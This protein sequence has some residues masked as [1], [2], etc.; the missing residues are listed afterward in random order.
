VSLY[1]LF[2]PEFLDALEGRVIG[3]WTG[4][5]WRVTVGQTSPLRTNSRGARWNPPGVEVLYASLDQVAAMVE[6]EHL[7]S[8]QSVTVKAPRFVSKLEVNLASVMDLSREDLIEPLGWSTKSLTSES[9]LLPQKIGA[10]AEFLQ[11]SGLLVPSARAGATNLVV[12]MKN[13][14]AKDI[15]RLVDTV[16]GSGS[17]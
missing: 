16:A 2:D 6:L 15:V 11:V 3:P 13:Q 14:S 12:L 10:A 9:W 7:L 17:E 1:P 5:A 8:Q 4:V